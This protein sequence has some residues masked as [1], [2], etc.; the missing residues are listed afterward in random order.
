MLRITSRAALALLGLVVLSGCAANGEFNPV[1]QNSAEMTPPQLAAFAAKAQ[2]PA[3]MQASNDLRVAAIV[4]RDK[5]TIEVYNFTDRP[6]SDAK[7]WV[8]KGFVAKVDGIAPMSKVT[9]ATSK[10]YGPF[11]NTFASQEKSV[12]SVQL[13]TSNGLFNL[14]GPV[15]Q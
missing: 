8:N 7:V 5:E 14:M 10:L 3:D 4:S 6:F 15:Q 12:S 11:G 1:G 13:E 9:I 2:Y